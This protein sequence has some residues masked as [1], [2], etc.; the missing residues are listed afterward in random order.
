[1]N[2]K[3]DGKIPKPRMS[4]AEVKKL[5]HDLVT[6]QVF[7]SDRIRDPEKELTLVFP[8]LLWLKKQDTQK[9]KKD[10]IAHFY[11]YNKEAGPRAINGY[12]MFFSCHQINITD[13]RRV[14]EEERRMRVALGE[15]NEKERGCV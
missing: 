1:M 14:I 7:M 12:P 13:Y 3:R 11:E 15:I 4:N 8:V 5:A 2:K 6:N 10:Q 9:L